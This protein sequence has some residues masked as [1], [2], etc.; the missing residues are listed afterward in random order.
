MR[1]E[2]KILT[3]KRVRIESEH[4]YIG[5]D[6]RTGHCDMH[7]GEIER[8]NAHAD[9]IADLYDKHEETRKLLA[10]IK[11]CI[12]V[13][14][15][16]NEANFKMINDVL[17]RAG[18]SIESVSKDVKKITDSIVEMQKFKW[19]RDWMNNARDNLPKV[20]LYAILA[21]LGLFVIFHW[22]DIGNVIRTK[23]LGLPK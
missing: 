3:E 12:E 7:S 13:S 22:L 21:L 10:S 23:F 20:V 9:Q 14:S 4:P 5:A 15:T 2:D 16:K 19:F 18:D 11:T 1:K 17:K 6:R 8:T